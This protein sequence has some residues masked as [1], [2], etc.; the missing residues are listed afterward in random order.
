MGGTPYISGIMSRNRT[1][2]VIL[3]L[4]AAF[5]SC[6]GQ[7]TGINL[8]ETGTEIQGLQEQEQEWETPLPPT[9]LCDTLA[10]RETRVLYAH[11]KDYYTSGKTL[12]GV[13]M[14]TLF[15]IDNWKYWGG[16][17]NSDT[18]HSDT[19][20]LAGSHPAVCG[21]ELAGIE[22]GSDRDVDGNYFSAVREHI[23]AAYARGAVNTISWHCGNPATDGIYNDN[24]VTG[25]VERILPGGDLHDKFCL[26]MDRTA[27]FLS[28]LTDSDGKPIPIIFRPWHEHTDRGHGSGF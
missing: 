8:P 26:R 3:S 23:K 7:W 16:R 1:V 6:D 4:A 14:P 5:T 9:T 11:L 17:N 27:A 2:I 20:Y 21:W 22:K 18:D 15:G 24:S 12:F 28:S 25:V 19:K 10:T 13:Q